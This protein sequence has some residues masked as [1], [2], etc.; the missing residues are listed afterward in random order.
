MKAFHYTAISLGE[1]ILS[2]AISQGH[3]MHSDGAMTHNVVWLTTDPGPYGHGLTLGNERLSAAQIAH[4]ERVVGG[5]LRN[6]RTLDKTQ[7][8]IGVELDASS[9]P[10]LISFM[11]YCKANE[12]KAFAKWYGLSCLVDMGSVSDKE[13]K[14]LA[15]AATTKETTWWLS[16]SPVSPE[17]FI[18]VDFSVEGRFEPYD[19]EQHGRGALRRLGFAFPSMPTLVEVAELIPAAHRFE[20]PKAFV[21]CEDPNKSPKVVFRGGAAMRA[22]EITSR[23]P[24]FGEPC[25]TT[26][27]LQAWILRHEEELMACWQEAV[28]LYYEAYPDRRP[29]VG[30]VE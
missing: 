2:S 12:S 15:R 26:A 24:F 14:R 11:D 9:N 3:L 13:L 22:F 28:E 29:P 8:R 17:A 25:D 30:P 20:T 23:N 19:F 16:F 1:A 18:S 21:F 4:E 10:G 6:A 7:L 27:D 5:P